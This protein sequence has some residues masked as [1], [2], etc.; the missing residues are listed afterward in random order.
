L[1]KLKL[2]GKVDNHIINKA[3][4]NINQAFSNNRSQMEE[5]DVSLLPASFDK[6]NP[7]CMILSVALKFKNENPILLTSDNILQ[8]R[9]QGLGIRAISLKDLK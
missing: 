3:A 1:D 6:K 2:N 8:T 4:R 5:A 9:A 7:D